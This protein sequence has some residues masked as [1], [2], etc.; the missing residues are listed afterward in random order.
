[1]K[2]LNLLSRTYV[3][4]LAAS[5]ICALSSCKKDKPEPEDKDEDSKPWLT[6]ILMG[7]FTIN[8][9]DVVTNEDGKSTNMLSD[10]VN[11][12]ALPA[13]N[14]EYLTMNMYIPTSSNHG[15]TVRNINVKMT[16]MG[17]VTTTNLYHHE[18]SKFQDDFVTLD[19]QLY[20]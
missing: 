1:M 3:L 10:Y 13:A 5:F 6:T 16:S 14:F 7:N 12:S 15:V 17:S 20:A 11:T 9:V 18:N 2:N 4:L 19:G 8:S